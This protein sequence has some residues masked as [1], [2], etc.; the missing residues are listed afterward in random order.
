MRSNAQRIE[1]EEKKAIVE[2]RKSQCKSYGFK[3]GS[4]SFAKC[5]IQQE[6]SEKI[7][8][9]TKQIIQI[10]Q[11]KM[12]M[13]RNMFNQE[14]QLREKQIINQRPPSYNCTQTGTFINCTGF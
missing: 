11:Q 6:N 5:I 12:Q 7:E 13:Q 2:R 10:E 9:Q 1:D 3:I 4:D 14:M 8:E